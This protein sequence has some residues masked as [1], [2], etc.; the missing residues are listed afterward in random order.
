MSEAPSRPPWKQFK[1][2]LQAQGFRP[3]RRF[4]QN[5]LLDEN[6]ARAIVAD[7]GVVAG[8]RVLEIG[9][10]CGFLTVHLAHAGVALLTVEIDPRLADVAESFLEPY[11]NVRLV[12]G[13][14][15]AGKHRLHPEVEAWSEGG[16]WHL[17]ANLPYAISGPLLALV[18]GLE[19]PPT[20]ITVLVQKEM[21]HRLVAQSGTTDYGP[22][23]A[24]L[25][26]VYQGGILRDVGGASFWPRP[27]VESSV[28]RLQR[29]TTFPPAAERGLALGRI[30]TLF[31]RRR[32]TLVR[33]MGDLGADREAL[34]AALAQAGMAADV[35]A[36]T[37]DANTLRDWV[38]GPHWPQD[39]PETS[40]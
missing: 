17:V 22:L 1:E 7:A 10:G 12:R 24:G 37:L 21:A 2:A 16:P 23:T 20:S 8:D 34:R 18:G 13:D 31:T 36:E 15:L 33:V 26:W 39:G 25:S 3:S 29:R 14:A 35:R 30:R 6:T 9:T 5:F 40:P 32:Q 19:T 11:A 38:L 4:G 27:K 28:V